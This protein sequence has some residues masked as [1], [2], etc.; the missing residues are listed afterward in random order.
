MD[1]THLLICSYVNRCGLCSSVRI[2]N[3]SSVSEVDWTNCNETRPNNMTVIN[4]AFGELYWESKSCCS[5]NLTIKYR[6]GRGSIA[7]HSTQSN[8]PRSNT[9]Y[10]GRETGTPLTIKQ[11]RNRLR[12]EMEFGLLRICSYAN[13]CG[14]CSSVTIEN[15]SSVSEVDCTNCNDTRPYNMTVINLAFEELHW[16]SKSCCSGSL[17]IKYQTRRVSCLFYSNQRSSTNHCL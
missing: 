1:S 17:T 13:W 14:L 15:A 7:V 10:E 4:S 3:A 6:T 16:E 9:V 5:G 8:E 11:T 12:K 2:E